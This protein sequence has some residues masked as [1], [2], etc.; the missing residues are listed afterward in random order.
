MMKKR[1]RNDC[2]NG[3]EGGMTKREVMKHAYIYP[4][5]WHIDRRTELLL[6]YERKMRNSYEAFQASNSKDLAISISL[7]L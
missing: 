2:E 1:N 5:V 7:Q 6:S 3:K 4:D